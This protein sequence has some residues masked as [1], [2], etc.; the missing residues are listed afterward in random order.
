[1]RIAHTAIVTPHRAGLYETARDLCAAERKA[2][3]DARI[4]DPQAID[5][6]RGVPVG[7]SFNPSDYD[8][9]IN[10][11]GLGQHADK[12]NGTPVIH[13]LHGRPESS[14]RLT[15]QKRTPV[16]QYVRNTAANESFKRWVTFWPETVPYWSLLVPPERLKVITAPVDLEAWTPEGPNGYGWHGK[17]GKY[18]VVCADM[19]REDKTPYHV[20]HGFCEFAKEVPGAK[21]HLYGVTRDDALDV[22][23]A[24]IGQQGWLGEVR[25]NV[26]G[27]ENVY[28]AATMAISP[29][30]I[31]TRS[32]RE[33]LSCGCPVVSAA[34]CGT[35]RA[36]P[37]DPRAFGEE[38]VSACQM[39]REVAREKAMAFDA[40]TTAREMLEIV[41]EVCDA[42]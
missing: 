29:H 2:G 22:L 34:A 4:I 32:I 11:S 7:Q 41:A 14:F 33:A 9:I 42:G 19:W 28:R 30:R 6:D 18:N 8:V 26:D 1:M 39:M 36:D 15:Q 37:E 31:A 25:G 24:Q 38:M 23:L 40:N 12:L 17:G 20:I 10:H 27:L 16:Y 21:L 35:N 5:E 3:V 13:C